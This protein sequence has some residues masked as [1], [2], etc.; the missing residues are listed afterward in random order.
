M[1]GSSPTSVPPVPPKSGVASFVEL[2]CPGWVSVTTGGALISQLYLAGALSLPAASRDFTSK[3]CGP[4]ASPE[5]VAG[6]VQAANA[7][8]SR[9]QLKPAP[10]SPENVNVAA[11]ELVGFGGKESIGGVGGGVRS[12][13]HE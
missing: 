7:P 3:E 13:V 9:R 6:L 1:C 4:S 2:P 10:A 12:T 11:A 5:Y 8:W